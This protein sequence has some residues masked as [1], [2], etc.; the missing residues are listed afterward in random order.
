VIGIDGLRPGDRLILTKPLGTGVVLAADMQ[1]RARGAWLKAGI[2][3]MLRT[4]AAAARIAIEFRASASTD[5][6]G[7][8]LAGHLSELLRASNRSAALLLDAIPALPGALALVER[9]MRSSYHEQNRS[10][11][12]GLAVPDSLAAHPAL[13]LLFDPQTSGGLLFAVARESARTALA[14]LRDAGDSNAA[15]IGTVTHRRS[16]GALFE[17]TLSSKTSR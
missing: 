5:V 1:G 17:V 12:R 3:S 13:E 2:A 11:R 14:A 15:I 8:G 16:D 4:N 6:S 7:F 10:G 9:G